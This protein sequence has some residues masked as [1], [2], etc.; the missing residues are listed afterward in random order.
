MR[1][2][3]K[4]IVALDID[5]QL[6]ERTTKLIDKIVARNSLY[7]N[8]SEMI[9]KRVSELPLYFQQQFQKNQEKINPQIEILPEGA[10][11]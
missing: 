1:F 6:L 9:A 4:H 3:P 10:C 7:L 8:R 5:A 11:F 2:F